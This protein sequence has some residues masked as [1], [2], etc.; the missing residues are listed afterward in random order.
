MSFDDIK[1]VIILILETDCPP[2][3]TRF[4]NESRKAIHNRKITDMACDLLYREFEEYL[5]QN[6]EAIF[7]ILNGVDNV[8]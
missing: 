8:Q 4:I 5:K 7:S 1:D 3:A 6:H 2:K